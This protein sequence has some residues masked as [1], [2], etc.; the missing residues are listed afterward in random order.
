MKVSWAIEKYFS[1]ILRSI[2]AG[3]IIVI[4]SWAVENNLVYFGGYSS[5]S[6]IVIVFW[7]YPLVDL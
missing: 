2:L 4:V 1:L 6:M 7:S 3:P 5:W